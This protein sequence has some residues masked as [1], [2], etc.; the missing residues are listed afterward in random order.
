ML[1]I[2]DIAAI[3]KCRL[4]RIDPSRQAVRSLAPSGRAEVTDLMQEGT[5]A[6]LPDGPYRLKF[7][8]SRPH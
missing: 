3:S 4:P 2:P 7:N 5:K 1:Y 6:A 8:R